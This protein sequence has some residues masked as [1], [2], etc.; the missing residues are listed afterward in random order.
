MK[1]RDSSGTSMVIPIYKSNAYLTTLIS[2]ISRQSVLPEEV[3]FAEDDEDAETVSILANAAK[4]LPSIKIKLVQQPD[5]G[6]R[7]AEIVNKAVTKAKNKRLVFLDGD[8]LPHPKYVESY[9]LRLASQVVLN[10]RPVRLRSYHRQLFEDSKGNFKPVDLIRVLR[11]C[12]PPRRY[13]VHIKNY[14]LISRNRSFY[15]SSWACMKDDFFHVNGYDED[16]CLGGYG[17][18]DT[19]LSH[20][21]YRSGAKLFNTKFRSIYYHFFEQGDRDQRESSKRINKVLLEGNDRRQLVRC[22]NGIDKW[23]GKVSLSYES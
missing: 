15:G 16:F 13:A 1:S 20:R 8:C 14:P 22:K 3:I 5:V 18:E 4:Q 21:F 11:M 7:K 6:F 2:A 23:A 10:S 9:T 17:F 19:D 12:E